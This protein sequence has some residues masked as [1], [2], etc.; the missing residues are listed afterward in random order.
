M[1][2]EISFLSASVFVTLIWVLFRAV[3]NFI[4][5]KFDFK[6]ELRLLLVYICIMVVMR[7]TFFP[8]EKINGQIQ[9]LLFSFENIFPFRINFVPFANLFDYPEKRSAWLNIIGNTTM[10]IPI[11][12]IWP[13]VF[14]KLDS[15]KKVIL[16]GI[17]FSLFV[18]I[19]QLPFFD[20]VTDID[21]LILNSA[22]FILGYLIYLLIKKLR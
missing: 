21:D 11:G 2:T 14:K 17:G 4:V 8:F 1:M 3:Y 10:F 18:E 7:I 6:R 22:G 13:S 20:R 19:L 9:P 15:H 5:K 12:I 16:S